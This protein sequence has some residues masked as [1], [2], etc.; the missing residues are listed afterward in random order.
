[1]PAD[2]I[3]KYKEDAIREMQLSRVPASITLAQGML[4]SDNGNSALAVYANNHFG[5]KCHTEWTG[6][7]YIQDDDEKNECFRKYKSV[8]DSY[9]DHSKFLTTRKRYA[10][11]FELKTTDYKGWARGLKEAGYAT[12]PKYADRLID[13]IERNKLYEFD[14]QQPLPSVIVQS[15]PKPHTVSATASG[16]EILRNNEVKCV[17]VKKGDTFYKLAQ[18]LGLE[19]WQLY[20]YNELDQNAVLKPGQMIYL[21]PKRKKSRT[22][23]SHTV[24]PGETLYQISQ[25]YGVKLSALYKINKL[26]PGAEIKTGD[27]I[28]LRRK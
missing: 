6:D 9:D 1:M 14:V 24:K 17:V 15:K 21:Q 11:L 13:I 7:T 23:Q 8:F 2:Y 10:F 3:A 22:E 5:I 4:E 25:Q 26:Q 20:K 19:V 28:R 18:E 12:D 16:R 27:V